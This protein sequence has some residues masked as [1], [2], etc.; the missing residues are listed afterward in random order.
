MTI[1]L[2]DVV[3]QSVFDWD[4][5]IAAVRDAYAAADDDARYPER[6]IARGGGSF[7]RTL[8]GVPGDGGLMGVK[9]LTGARGGRPFSSLVSLCAQASAKLVAL[10]AGNSITGYRT[11]ATSALAV[12]L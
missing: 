5:A 10:L 3:V 2:D 9:P 11:A 4:A 8:S 12:D 7:L 1:L 6:V